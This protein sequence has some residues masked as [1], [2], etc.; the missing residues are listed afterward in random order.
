[1]EQESHAGLLSGVISRREEYERIGRERLVAEREAERA[2]RIRLLRA[3]FEVAF[4]CLV[5][6]AIM[7]FAFY[8]TD[9]ELGRILL[10]TGM[11]I[12]YAGMAV[13]LGVAFLRA[14]DHGDI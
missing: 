7:F 10:L 12:G 2:G 1:V 6:A 9:A 4:A 8:V 11:V 14:K 13:A 5:G 3:C